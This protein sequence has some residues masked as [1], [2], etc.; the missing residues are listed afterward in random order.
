MCNIY[1][2]LSP[3]D[4]YNNSVSNYIFIPGSLLIVHSDLL[5][6]HSSF[7]YC[8]L[9]EISPLKI[10]DNIYFIVCGILITK[11]PP[12]TYLVAE[13]NRLD[14]VFHIMVGIY[15]TL[16]APFLS[17]IAVQLSFFILLHSN[18]ASPLSVGRCH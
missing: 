13:Q 10:T 7:I 12:K 9:I 15:E 16:Y 8:T 14:I 18:S 2:E 3:R 11:L 17:G 5:L 6:Y 4:D 1:C